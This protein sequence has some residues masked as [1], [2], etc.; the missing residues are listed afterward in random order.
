MGAHGLVRT[1]RPQSLAAPDAPHA[2]QARSASLDRFVPILA[3]PLPWDAFCSVGMLFVPNDDALEAK[4]KEIFEKVAAAEDFKVR[5]IAA[6]VGTQAGR[7]SSHLQC[8]GSRS[9][10]HE[11]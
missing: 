9:G 6:I 5:I 1:S 11:Q 8:G 4:C 7:A 2:A 3:L 10:D